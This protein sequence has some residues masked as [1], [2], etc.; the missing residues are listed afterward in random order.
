MSFERGSCSDA[1]KVHNS[2]AIQHYSD[3]NVQHIKKSWENVNNG[4]GVG[5][6]QTFL[7]YIYIY[8]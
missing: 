1:Y 6:R 5:M 3:S 2:Q 7:T 4:G 8:I